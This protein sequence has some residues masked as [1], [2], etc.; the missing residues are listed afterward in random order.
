MSKVIS[1]FVS[2]PTQYHAPIFREL[3]KNENLIINIYYF[4]KH[5][6]V[7][8][9]DN[10]FKKSFKWDGSLLKYYKYEFIVEQKSN[11][12]IINI[13]QSLS[14][15]KKCIT[16]S[17][18][19][20]VFGWNN[21]FYLSIIFY[22]YISSKILILLAENNLLKKKNFLIKK[23]KRI[24]LYFFLKFFDYFLSIGTNN[25]NYY[26]YHGV[27]K[28]KIY[29]TFYTVDTDFFKNFNSNF[30]FSK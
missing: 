28:N 24:I 10:D 22:A 18:A 7:R 17:D 4:Y 12:K 3:S 26:L 29:Q 13:L 6:S 30:A 8:S 27:N 20:L 21:F 25:K 14:K 1:I 2:H 5:G 16:N 11:I 15:I 19:V 23:I 9:Y